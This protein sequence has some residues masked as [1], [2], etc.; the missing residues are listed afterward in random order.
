MNPVQDLDFI[1]CITSG[2]RVLVSKPE[3]SL[4]GDLRAVPCFN[5][6]GHNL[7]VAN[8]ISLILLTVFLLFRQL[9]FSDSANCISLI[10]PI[11]FLSFCRLYFSDSQRPL[12]LA[13][14]SDGRRSARR[15][16]AR[17]VLQ[18]CLGRR[19]RDPNLCCSVLRRR[20]PSKHVSRAPCNVVR[21]RCVFVFVFVFVIVFVFVFV[22]GFS[23]RTLAG[24]ELDPAWSV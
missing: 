21:Y 8:C 22:F 11:V 4:V 7:N 23:N 3:G 1:N 12:L 16:S 20:P 9:Y 24:C 13:P 19:R 2:P 10:P 14:E 17:V 5:K 18:E 15:A 6:L